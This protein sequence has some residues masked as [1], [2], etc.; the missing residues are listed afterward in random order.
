MFA[1]EVCKLA[2][3]LKRNGRGLILSSQSSICAARPTSDRDPPTSQG[4]DLPGGLVVKLSVSPE[5]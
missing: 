3:Q 1:T 4:R 2:A 5:T